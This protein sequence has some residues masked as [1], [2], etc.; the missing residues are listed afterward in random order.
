MTHSEILGNY[1]VEDLKPFDFNFGDDPNDREFS[2]SET[3]NSIFARHN[4]DLNF[5]TANDPIPGLD[6]E[7]INFS[8]RSPDEA[9]EVM[10]VKNSIKLIE[11]SS[12]CAAPK[13]KPEYEDSDESRSADLK[14]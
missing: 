13:I 3:Y 4:N 2:I 14:I 11:E 6:K 12:C 1:E 9:L 10:E 8:Q 7:H 5:L